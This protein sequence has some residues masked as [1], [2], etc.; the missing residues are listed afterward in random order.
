VLR[1]VSGR[2]ILSQK[3]GEIATEVHPKRQVIVANDLVQE[4]VVAECLLQRTV[5]DTK[6][7]MRRCGSYGAA[8]HGN[9]DAKCSVAT[10]QRLHLG[11]NARPKSGPCF[12][13]WAGG[14]PEGLSLVQVDVN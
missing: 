7:D 6:Y 14:F 12:G 10:C 1:F 13:D 8:N 9:V 5:I 11:V 3:L 2:R 4:A